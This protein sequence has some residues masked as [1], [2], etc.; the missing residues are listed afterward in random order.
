MSQQSRGLKVSEPFRGNKSEATQSDSIDARNWATGQTVAGP[1][2]GLY[3]RTSVSVT[4]SSYA[5][6]QPSAGKPKK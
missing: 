6:P 2:T 1:T 5:E 3:G 4:A